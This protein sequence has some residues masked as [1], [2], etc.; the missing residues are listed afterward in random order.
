MADFQRRDFLKAGLGFLAGSLLPAKAFAAMI[1][2]MQMRRTLAFYNVHTQEQIEVCYFDQDGYRF[3]ALTQIDHIL[4]DHRTGKI[5]P[6][7]TSLIDLLYTVQCQIR[8]LSPFSIISGYRSPETNER[9]RRASSGV[10][11]R[12]LHTKGQAIDIRLPGYQTAKLRDLCVTLQ[13]GGVGYYPKSD[14]VHLD[15]GPVRTW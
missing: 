15:I 1:S 11:K 5:N 2:P 6:I 10:A 4:R 3:E 8:P 7:D 13:S 9:L 14:F 12:S